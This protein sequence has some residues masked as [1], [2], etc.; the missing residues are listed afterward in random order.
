MWNEFI[1]D[2]C[3]ITTLTVLLKISCHSAEYWFVDNV[4][5]K[6]A[7]IRLNSVLNE[8]QYFEY[9]TKLL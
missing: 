5:L 8:C 7:E 9:G 1:V 4:F 3:D 6:N 2:H